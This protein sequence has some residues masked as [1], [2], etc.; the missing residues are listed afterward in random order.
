MFHAHNPPRPL[1]D[2]EKAG[3]RDAMRD[4]RGATIALPSRIDVRP[5]V[6]PEVIRGIDFLFAVAETND[7]VA[8]ADPED[9]A[10]MKAA[11]EWLAKVRVP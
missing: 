4:A 6:P 9:L 3:I 8:Y 5:V 11:G 7:H 10:A 2:E 1:T